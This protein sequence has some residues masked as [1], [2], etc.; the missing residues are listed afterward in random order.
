MSRRRL[1]VPPEALTSHE[2][3]LEDE[4]HHHL[5]RVLRVTA[6]EE[7]TLFDGRG[8]EA[9][10]RVVAVERERTRL[11][12][13]ARR[14]RPLPRGA[15]IILCQAVIRP[16][17]MDWVVQKATELGVKRLVPTL[18]ERSQ[19]HA[20][21]RSER[22]TRIARE[23]AR[24]CGRADVPAIDDVTSWAEALRVGPAEAQRL[25]LWEDA[26]GD[27]PFGKVARPDV[28]TMVLAVGPEGGL[29]AREVG[30]ARDAG[31]LTT[32][33]GPRILRAETAAVVALAIAQHLTGGLG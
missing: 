16:E 26:A 14:S 18:C 20:R 31:F 23:A 4:A 3:V 9:D 5:A 32:G 24:Q 8:E 2:I 21:E 1:F 22:W 30:T 33:L 7:V 11:A 17:K 15:E 27:S 29:S 6:A 19:G 13:L 12:I 10:A 28:A 25:V